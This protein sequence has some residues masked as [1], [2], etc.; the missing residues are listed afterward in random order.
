MV[1]KLSE[2]P[3]GVEKR[4]SL[5]GEDND[6]VYCGMLNMSREELASLKETGVI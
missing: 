5:L 4:A 3:G 1:V 2:T 6:D